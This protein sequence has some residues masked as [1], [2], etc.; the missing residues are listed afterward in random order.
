[1]KAEFQNPLTDINWTSYAARVH[2]LN[3]IPCYVPQKIRLDKRLL[4]LEEALQLQPCLF[5]VGPAGAGKTANLRNAHINLLYQIP[6]L[7]P[8]WVQLDL[9]E[10]KIA[11]LGLIKQE[12]G[13]YELQLTE[14]DIIRMLKSTEVVLIMDGWTEVSPDCRDH[15]RKDFRRWRSEYP[16]HR[17]IISGRRNEIYGISNDAELGFTGLTT[18]ELQPFSDADLGQFFFKALGFNLELEKLPPRLKEAA[19]WPL[20]AKMIAQLWKEKGLVDATYIAEL[21]EHVLRREH[22]KGVGTLPDSLRDEMDEFITELGADM[23]HRL[24]TVMP[25]PQARELIR[26]TWSHFRCSGR[27]VTAEEST[28][29]AVFESPLIVSD[30][31]VVRFAH[32]IFQEFFAGRWLATK[33][34]TEPEQY[35]SFVSDPWWAYSVVFAAAKAPDAGILLELIAQSR[36]IWA[37]S[38]LL[39]GDTGDRP[40]DYCRTV[41]NS[42]LEKGEDNRRFA[43]HCLAETIDDPWACERLL[44]VISEEDRSRGKKELTPTQISNTILYDALLPF[45]MYDY[46]ITRLPL[47]LFSKL[48]GLSPAARFA[49]ANALEFIASSG[50]YGENRELVV[51]LLLKASKD[52][53]RPVRSMAIEGLGSLA[54]HEKYS[55]NREVPRTVI[56]ALHAASASGEWPEYQTAFEYLHQIDEIKIDEEWITQQVEFTIQTA[57]TCL[58]NGAR[59]LVPL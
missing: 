52:S 17:Y 22:A 13:R 5:V 43:I 54:F 39:A 27:I 24:V 31:N 12:L 55:G 58:S 38:R 34:K 42:S 8:I 53:S 32:Q 44:K 46:R 30:G 33:L 50:R 19:Q 49:I 59:N 47:Q 3:E 28:I 36:N 21:V 2:Q 16:H 35:K 37:I 40:R 41:I 57:E 1:M 7:I 6:R 26:E 4:S 18:A 10:P 14:V 25:R 45:L 15:L 51:N 20:Y 48:E 29:Q 9:Y 56:D 11:L 23:H